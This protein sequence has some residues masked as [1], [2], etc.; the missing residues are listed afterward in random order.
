[1][2]TGSTFGLDFTPTQRG[3]IV[4]SMLNLSA[5][6]TYTARFATLGT[7]G[8]LVQFAWVYVVHSSGDADVTVHDRLRSDGTSDTNTFRV[9][10]KGLVAVPVRRSEFPQQSEIRIVASANGFRGEIHIVTE[11][12]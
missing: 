2:L 7:L 4:V 3:S 1:M 8:D 5:G 6:E 9:P 12:L 11:Q 10:A